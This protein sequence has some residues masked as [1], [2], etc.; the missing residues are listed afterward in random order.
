MRVRV[1]GS[2]GVSVKE[3]ESVR[4]KVGVLCA[5]VGVGVSE[6]ESERE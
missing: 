1:G 2:V 3:Y 4:V 5:S 6:C